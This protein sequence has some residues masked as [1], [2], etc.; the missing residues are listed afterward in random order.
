MQLPK[1]LPI[2]YCDDAIVAVNKPSGLLVHRSAIDRHETRFAVQTLRDQLGKRVYPVHR[3]DKPTSGVLLFAFSPEMTQKIAANWQAVEKR[4]LAITRGKVSETVLNHPV[5]TITESG[6]EKIQDAETAFTPLITAQLPISFGKRAVEFNYTQFS[7]LEAM[8]K[9][10]R[11]HQIRKHLKHLN[12][13]IVGD[14]RYGRGEINRYF[15]EHYQLNRLMLHCQSMRLSHPLSGKMLA[16]YAPLD[17]HWY[18]LLGAMAWRR[19]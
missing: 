11:K 5:R 17:S 2:I 12:H 6:K 4:Y 7:L 9:T 8:P 16:L 15:R 1:K 13:P 19:Y 3:L 14:T 18:R 10:G